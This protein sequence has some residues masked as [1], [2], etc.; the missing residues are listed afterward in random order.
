ME[1]KNFK[2]VNTLIFIILFFLL[3]NFCFSAT[4]YIQPSTKNLNVGDNLTI[5]VY[6]DSSD[7]SMN[8][9]SG[10]IT[11]DNNILKYV[12]H[13]KIGSIFS[14]WTQEPIIEENELTFEGVVFNPGFQGTSGKIL[15]VNF[16]AIKPGETKINFTSG[17]VL[18]ND[19]LGTN[20]LK[21][22]NG[23]IYKIVESQQKEEIIVKEE[24]PKSINI[25]QKPVIT[26][27]T[28]PNQNEW[29]KNNNPVF[30]WKIPSGVDLVKIGYGKNQNI[31]PT[32]EYSPPIYKKTLENIPDGT[33]YFA[34]Q[35]GNKFGKSEIARFKF[36]IDTKAPNIS[37]FSLVPKEDSIYLK[38][39]AH[40][41]LSGLDK[42]EIYL[43]DSLYSK[44]EFIDG[45]ITKL[46]TGIEGSK[47]I[48]IVVKDK[49]DNEIIKEETI[50]FKPFAK[51]IVIEKGLSLVNLIILIFI[52]ILLL[53]VLTSIIALILRFK[54]TERKF[55][56]IHW[57]EFEAK[58]KDKYDKFIKS[59]KEII[60]NLDNDP[61]FS[62]E[63]RNI[64][65]KFKE[66]IDKAEK[67]FEEYLKKEK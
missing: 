21:S 1:I 54:K 61:K 23:G 28:H 55:Q 40:D 31:I 11:W 47:K 10:R 42:C 22:M 17:M 32:I 25:P 50:S 59:M 7:Q 4:L 29:Y 67:E 20:I 36:N 35:F 14:F 60:K 37:E 52:I 41:E 30:E 19:G 62:E 64:Y 5:T 49:A 56:E 13:S 16:K 33:Y 53:I 57:K 3:T 12:S 24:T 39:V 46:L 27:L 45:T 34:V 38:I 65:R 26:S 8:A 58:Y 18:A 2:I 9:A 51:P 6:V 48:K 66:M 43:D 44:E 63:E 15:T